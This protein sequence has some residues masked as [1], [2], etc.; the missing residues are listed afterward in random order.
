MSAD[1]RDTLTHAVTAFDKRSSRGRRR[2]N[3]YALGHY[4]HGVD[5]VV[6]AVHGGASP[7]EA[8]IAN[9]ND[10]LR[11]AVLRSLD[12]P[13]TTP[14]ELVAADDAGVLDFFLA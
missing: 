10:R 12:E 14:G 13:S 4:L 2:P 8:V 7:R 3:V 9:F 1:L 5:R 6:E 11:D